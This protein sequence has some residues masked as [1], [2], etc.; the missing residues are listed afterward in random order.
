MKNT[1]KQDKNLLCL[2]FRCL[3]F[4]NALL[5]AGFSIGSAPDFSSLASFVS[6]THDYLFFLSRK[7][8]ISLL[9]TCVQVQNFIRM[10]TNIAYLSK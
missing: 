6:F 3:G 7:G 2:R 4:F 8:N 5:G 1:P 10:P 9:N